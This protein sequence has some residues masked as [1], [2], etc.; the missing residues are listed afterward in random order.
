MKFVSAGHN[1]GGLKPDPGA[2]GVNGRKE[3][4]E[5]IS[6]R[7]LVISEFKRLNVTDYIT[8]ND[9]ERLGEYLE[10]IKTGNGSVVLEFHFDAGPATATGTTVFIE[11]DADRL[12]K[13]FANQLAKATSEILGIKDRGVR[14]EIE[15]HRGKLGLMREQG[16]VA[17]LEICFISNVQDMQLYDANKT[18]LAIKI[19]ELIIEFDKYI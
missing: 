15:S 12:D 8:D 18:K 5:T 9:N 2:I 14:S 19:A 13:A 10:R 11:E 4:V 7:N 3:A 16:I 6:F 17:L 1:T